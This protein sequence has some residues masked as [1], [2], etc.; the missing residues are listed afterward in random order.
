MNVSFRME[1]GDLKTLLMY[2]VREHLDSSL[3]GMTLTENKIKVY[4]L[5]EYC[6]ISNFKY[7]V[8]KAF[9]RNVKEIAVDADNLQTDKDLVNKFRQNISQD[10]ELVVLVKSY[11]EFRLR[12]KNESISL[13]QGQ[14]GPSLPISAAGS[15]GHASYGNS[16]SVVPVF[17]E[18]SQ[19]S[20]LGAVGLYNIGNT[21]YMNSALQ[22]LSHT[23]VFVDYFLQKK[24]SEDKNLDNVLGSKGKLVEATAELLFQM[25]NGTQSVV[26]PQ[27]FK[28]EM[29]SFHNQFEGMGQQ[30]SQEF[31]SRLIDGLHEDLNLIQKKPYVEKL[32]AK[33]E[34]S[35]ESVGR[36]SWVGNLKRDYS[37]IMNIFYGQFKNESSCPQCPRRVI[38]FEPFQLISLAVPK[39]QSITLSPYYITKHHNS[40]AQ[41]VK[42]EINFMA[43]KEP[44]IPEV[45]S[46]FHDSRQMTGE[47]F[48][49]NSY[50][51][52]F[53]GFETVGKIIKPNQSLS[54]IEK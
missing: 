34:D 41:K 49:A 2:Q 53:V 7:E 50:F 12:G 37:E 11:T 17:P 36:Q 46:K 27:K 52:A 25:H 1:I 16:Y 4:V 14:I 23:K 19:D 31:L 5:G 24:Y 48:D 40:Q 3:I 44:S 51:F 29:G 20:K 33:P 54:F 32:E 21:C 15:G 8:K 6:T 47:E 45:L 13:T 43:D 26:K 22:C 35:H 30:D 9:S 42:F 39:K 10:S 18:P 38:T 28:Y